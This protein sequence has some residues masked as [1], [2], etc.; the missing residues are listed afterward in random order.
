MRAALEAAGPHLGEE[1]SLLYTV[2]RIMQLLGQRD[3]V[4]AMFAAARKRF[5]GDAAVA[6]AAAKLKV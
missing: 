5:P 6:A 4:E 2:G 3:K 1:L